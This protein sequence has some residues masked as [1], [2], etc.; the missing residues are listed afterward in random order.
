M[1]KM[2]EHQMTVYDYVTPHE[3]LLDQSNRWLRLA[4]A[5]DWEELEQEYSAH[6][7]VSGK[8]AMPVRLAFGVLV[9]RDA[10]GLSDRETVRVIGESPYLQYFVGVELF[11]T[12][13]CCVPATLAK[14]RRR[15][16]EQRIQ[17]AV[18]L[19]REFSRGRAE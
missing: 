7:G 11:D 6:F 3:E 2:D 18:G 12:K 13:P 16:P 9:V 15:I 1:Y 17:Q 14:F 19:L 4:R 8:R 10:L 5:I